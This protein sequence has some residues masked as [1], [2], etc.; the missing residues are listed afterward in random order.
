MDGTCMHVRPMDG[1]IAPC[2]TPLFKTKTKPND[3][4]V[5]GGVGG[6]RGKAALRVTVTPALSWAVARWWSK[7][8]RR[9]T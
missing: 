3:R 7:P 4:R 2:L 6:A 9:R 1:P 8:R 5:G